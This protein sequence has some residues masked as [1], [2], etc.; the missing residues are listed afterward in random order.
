M[1]PLVKIEIR[2]GFSAEYKKAILDGVHQALVDAL[3][4]PDSDRFQRIYELDM[5]DFECP[6]DRTDAVTM[7]QITMFPGR[8]FNAKKKLYQAI[9]KNLGENPG[10]DGYDILIILLEPPMDNW[11]IRG[12]KPASEVDLGFKIDV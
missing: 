1:C 12:G 2:K 6:T 3:G 4:I 11:G 5:E 10:I 8:S 7:I 9:V